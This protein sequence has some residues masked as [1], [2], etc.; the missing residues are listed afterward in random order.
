[1]T[2]SGSGESGRPATTRGGPSVSEVGVVRDPQKVGEHWANIPT[3]CAAKIGFKS[4]TD[5]YSSGK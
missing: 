2:V 5:P 4:L 1:M 3:F